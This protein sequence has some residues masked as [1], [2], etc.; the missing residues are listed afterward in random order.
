[1]VYEN[2]LDENKDFGVL[3]SG[4][5]FIYKAK[6]EWV[7]GDA[8][9]WNENGTLATT[10]YLLLDI[11]SQYHSFQY[12]FPQTNSQLDRQMDRQTVRQSESQ[13]FSSVFQYLTQT[14]E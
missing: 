3:T 8:R 2:V 5:F 13:G 14:V 11:T 4:L 6:F 10:V 9:L 7:V 12:W 1:M